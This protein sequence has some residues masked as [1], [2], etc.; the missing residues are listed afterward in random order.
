LSNPAK[1]SASNINK[2]TLLVFA[3]NV[4]FSQWSLS[5]SG[6]PRPRLR[7]GNLGTAMLF[8]R[9]VRTRGASSAATEMRKIIGVK[10]ST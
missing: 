6:I 3:A 9:R 2:M 1:S 8:E 4:D 5:I 7:R 10:K